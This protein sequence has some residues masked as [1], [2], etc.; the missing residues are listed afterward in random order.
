M[1]V[2]FLERRKEIYIDIDS[3]TQQQKSDCW[4]LTYKY[5]NKRNKLHQPIKAKTRDK[6]RGQN[7]KIKKRIE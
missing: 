2:C 1:L 3:L 5:Q 7:L 6:T 4:K